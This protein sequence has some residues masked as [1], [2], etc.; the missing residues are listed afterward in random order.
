VN[1]TLKAQQAYRHDAQA[2]RTDRSVEYDAI[3]RITHALKTAAQ[4]D[5]TQFSELATAIHDNR[6]LWTIL[7]T[8]VADAHNALPDTLRARILYLAEFTRHHS[9]KVL[10]DGASAMPLVEVNTAILKGL[11]DKGPEQ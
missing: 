5:K 1:A 6:R 4:A 3:A 9:S 11:R 2:I 10:T 8:D 7:A